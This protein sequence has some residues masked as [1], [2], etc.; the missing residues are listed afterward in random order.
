MNKQLSIVIIAL[1]GSVLSC[2]MERVFSPSLPSPTPKSMAA[3]PTALPTPPPPPTMAPTP[4][5]SVR[6]ASG[7]QAL[8]NGDWDKAIREYQLVLDSSTDPE[9]QSAALLGIGRTFLQ[10]GEYAGALNSLRRLID[11]FPNA[12]QKAYAMFALAQT[13][14]KLDR[15]LEAAE[16]YGNYLQLHPGILDSHAQELRGD[17]LFFAREYQAAIN[18]YQEAL[19]TERAG[20]KLNIHIKIG[21]AYGTMGNHDTAIVIYQDVLGRTTN[22]YVKAQ[23]HLYIGQEHTAA[24]R[25]AEAHTAWL[26]AVE[27]YPLAY[28]SYLALVNLVDAGIPVS[29]LDRGLV[30]YFAGQ[31]APANSATRIQLSQL[32]VAAFDRYL[33]SAPEDHGDAAHFY[34][35]LALME[36]GD[37][38]SAIHEWDKQIAEHANEQ[39]WANAFD[40]KAFTQWAYLGDYAGGAQTLLDFAANYPSHPRTAEFLFYAGRTKERSGNLG[41]AAEIWRRIGRQYGASEYGHDGFFFAGI[42][43]YRNR[44]FNGAIEDFLGALGSTTNLGGQAK[45]HFWIGKAKHALNDLEGAQIAWQ[46]AAETDPTGYYSIRAKDMLE[47]RA[48][49]TIDENYSLEYD[50]QAEK[51]AAE[52]WMKITFALDNGTDLSGLG[53]LASHSGVVRGTE[54]WHLGLFNESRGEF[55]NLRSELQYDAVNSYRLANYLIELGLYRSG[56]MA[57]RQVLTLAGM[58]DAATMRAPIYFNRLRFG[59]YH[60]ELVV[61]AAQAYDFDRLFLFSVLRQ[62]SLFEGF[63]TSGAGARGLMQIMPGTGQSIADL[64]AWPTNYTANDLYRPMISVTFGADYLSRQRNLFDGN[65]PAALAAYNGGPGNSVEW[66]GLSQDDAD[67]FVEVIRFGETRNYVRGIYEIF[68]IYQ[69]IYSTGN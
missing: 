28:S 33:A 17:S 42:S 62:E 43:R 58:D 19:Q 60:A 49:F 29:E 59:T 21:D 63:V 53:P 20:D 34:R 36:A 7:D 31:T 55:E 15:H 30:D 67:L 65:L 48:A 41:E 66:L 35:G 47:G 9:L 68:R 52:V 44:D 13:Y 40:E 45:A 50:R 18:A 46:I 14:V 54:L 6:I 8:F 4:V 69:G 61:P 1:A 3:G 23:M 11:E 39:Y 38:T 32:A 57:T 26:Q 2:N 64:A 5:P 27:N 16:A 51:E 12:T 24:G 25:S 56:I 22:D 37:Y 10:M